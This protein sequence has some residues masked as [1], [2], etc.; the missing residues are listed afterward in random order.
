MTDIKTKYSVAAVKELSYDVLS[1]QI[2]IFEKLCFTFM[3]YWFILLFILFYVINY[4]INLIQSFILFYNTHLQGL[5]LLLLSTPFQST[6]KWTIRS[7]K[8][9]KF[10]IG[11][12]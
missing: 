4:F 1:L 9:I 8:C 10:D 2:M 6:N 11:G 5:T 12:F 7:W 3:S